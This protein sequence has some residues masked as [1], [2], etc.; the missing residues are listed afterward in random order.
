MHELEKKHNGQRDKLEE[1]FQKDFAEEKR[2]APFEE[3]N[4]GKQASSF[5]N[6]KGQLLKRELWLAFGIGL[7]APLLINFALASAVSLFTNNTSAPEQSVAPT[8]DNTTTIAGLT[9]P[10]SRTAPALN[11]TKVAG[12]SATRSTMTG[13]VDPQTLS[14]SYYWSMTLNNQTTNHQNQEARMNLTLPKGSVVSRATLWINGRS[15]DAAFNATNAVRRGY[16]WITVQHRDPLL[17]TQSPDGHIVVQMSPVPAS[18]EEVRIQLGITAPMSVKN[19][20]TLRLQLPQVNDSN[21]TISKQD[22]HLQ[23]PMPLYANSVK[24]KNTGSSGHFIFKGNVEP[25]ELAD[26]QIQSG[27]PKSLHAQFA[28]RATHSDS[29]SYIVASLRDNGSN[30]EPELSYEKVL[31]KPDCTFIS[32]EQAAHRVSTLWAAQEIKRL[33]KSDRSSAVSLGTAYRVVS[34]VTGAVVLETERDYKATNLHRDRYQTLAYASAENPSSAPIAKLDRDSD[35]PGPDAFSNNASSTTGNTGSGEP[36]DR[37]E[38]VAGSEKSLSQLPGTHSSS[39]AAADIQN[40]VAGANTAGTVRVNNLAHLGGLL[41]ALANG[42]EI[43]GIA[44]GGPTMLM[45]F[46]QFGAGSQAALRRVLW[47]AA[48]CSAGLATPGCLNWLVATARDANL[49]S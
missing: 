39:V 43:L 25:S 30:S 46:M 11:F 12:L 3:A 10:G 48:S 23:S 17:V 22:V 27:K 44:W 16:D 33:A 2:P 41:N 36:N 45:G 37:D 20:N 24:F 49:F 7:S 34:D 35:A 4:G 42:M 40:T 14:A 21:F 26:L 8:T 32:S 28:T 47:G 6:L 1:L 29:G 5:M 31:S 38:Q 9:R 18:G 15:E 13:I 19:S